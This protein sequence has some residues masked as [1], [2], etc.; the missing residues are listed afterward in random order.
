[1]RF[2]FTVT[3]EEENQSSEE[4]QDPVAEGD[5]EPKQVDAF[6]SGA[7]GRWC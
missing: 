6:Q 5:A 4:V 3:L 1:M 7:E 2:A